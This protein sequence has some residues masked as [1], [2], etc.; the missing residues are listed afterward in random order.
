MEDLVATTRVVG[1]IP[2]G[3]RASRIMPIPC[4]KELFPVGFFQSGVTGHLR[5]KTACHYVLERM[6]WAGIETAFIVVRKEKW[7]IP[8]YFGNG[9]LLDMHLGYLFFYLIACYHLLQNIAVL[10]LLFFLVSGLYKMQLHPLLLLSCNFLYR[11]LS[12]DFL[13][14]VLV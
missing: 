12:V 13:Q 8:S 11:T 10:L 14:I 1:L 4:S 3:G 9:S 6:R 7:D 5:P 2:A